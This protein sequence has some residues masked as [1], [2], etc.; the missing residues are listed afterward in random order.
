MKLLVVDDDPK[1][2]GYMERG[3]SDS[4]IECA[5][6]GDADEAA[7]LL[8]ERGPFD[9]ILLDVMMPGRDGWEFLEELRRGGDETPVLFLT[10]RHA[11]EERVKGLRL[12]ADDYI[13]KPFEL[14][15]LLARVEA[16][17]RRRDA[18]PCL[19]VADLRID[20]AHRVVERGGLRVETSPREFE[21]LQ[22]LAEARG[23]VLSRAELLRRVWGITFDPETNV[24]DVAVAR[25]RRKLGPA[26]R[27]RI[28]TV[29]GR[30]YR[31]VAEA[32]HE[33]G[34]A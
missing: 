31:L 13:I 34:A 32:Q 29:V 3:L 26:G 28:E 12:G 25:L 9:A 27:A 24:V 19:E 5:T 33:G 21:V 11:V 7:V 1:L 18:V 6:A 15:E 8:E 30:G 16:V 17:T 10:A 22:A 23:G 2:R 4:G 14:R 20:R